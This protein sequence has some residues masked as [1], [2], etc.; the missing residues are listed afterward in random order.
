MNRLI[1]LTINIFCFHYINAEIRISPINHIFTFMISNTW[2]PNT[3][4]MLWFIKKAYGNTIKTQIFQGI[5]YNFPINQIFGMQ[6]RQTR[7]TVETGSCHI[8]IV[9]NS[10]YVRIRIICIQNRIFKNSIS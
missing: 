8:I 5:I 9:P 4:T 7:N 1:P 2:R 3:F 6:D 10:N